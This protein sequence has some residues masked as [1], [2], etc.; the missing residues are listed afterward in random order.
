MNTQKV[1]QR[2]MSMRTNSQLKQIETDN[3]LVSVYNKE[4]YVYVPKNMNEMITKNLTSK[5]P[6]FGKNFAY[7]SYHDMQWKVEERDDQYLNVLNVESSI[8]HKDDKMCNVQAEYHRKKLVAKRKAKKIGEE[9]KEKENDSIRSMRNNLNFAER[10]SQ[11]FNP[12]IVTKEVETPKLLRNDHRGIAHKW[13]LFDRYLVKFVKGEDERKKEEMKKFG[14]VKKERVKKVEKQ[15]ESLSKPSLLKTLKL[16][17]RQILQILNMDPYYFYREWNKQEEVSDTKLLLM[18]LPFPQN[19][20]IR[21][22]S[23]TS[24]C[25]NP[26]YEDLFAVGYG[27]YAFPKKK[28]EKEKA[29]ERGEERSD[30]MLENGYIFVFSIK[31]NYFPEIKYTTESGVL[32]LDFHPKQFSYLVAGMYD[33]TVAVFDIKQKTKTPIV[34]CDIRYQKHMDPVWQVKWYTITELDEFV[35]YSISSDGKV[36]RW[37][38]FK[39]KTKLESE[40]IITLKYSE[41][42]AEVME[43][44]GAA[45]SISV[46]DQE[47]K[48]KADEAFIFGNSGGMC[49]DFNKHKGHEH[50][51]VLGTEEGHIHLCSVKHRGHYIQTYEGHSMG[52]YTVSWNP[53]HEKI[54]A[55]CSADWTIKI[56]HYKV[57]Q[58]LIIFDM[59]NA[60]GDVA[61]S[62]WCST[63]FSAVTV[64]GDMKFFDLNRNRKAAIHE[65]KYQDI[66]INHISFNKFEY[67]FLTGNE[68]G[69]VRLWRMAEPLYQTIDKRDEEEKEKKIQA[70]NQKSNVPENLIIVPKNLVAATT[71]QKKVVEIK[72]DNKMESVNSEVFLKNEKNRIVEFLNLLGIDK[73][74]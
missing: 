11:T 57:F 1:I 43:K 15:V 65:K 44:T 71:K 28:D 21:N 49:F 16:V 30:D 10:T 61:W 3:N 38:F 47:G 13:D 68:K 17:E 35:F 45:S 37:S 54:F 24:I 64:Q 72:K 52:V 59:Q 7:F 70:T 5:D 20:S 6:Q 58:P 74:L 51:F 2:R 67:V 48:E 31:N 46:I 22:R 63:I 9:F 53:F 29:D 8:L 32:S 73:D 42:A 69:K 60:V 55:S 18:L 27:S 56:W 19:A 62:P 12:E 41:S 26:K 39:N 34:V 40:E 36:I 25:W 33:G 50:L 66:A 23:V 4:E 14:T